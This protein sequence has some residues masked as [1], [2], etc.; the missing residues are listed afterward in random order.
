M[1]ITAQQQYMLQQDSAHICQYGTVF[2]LFRMTTLSL[3]GIE[4]MRFC[5]VVKEITSKIS[6]DDLR[7]PSVFAALVWHK[8]LQPLCSKR[9]QFETDLANLEANLPV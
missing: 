7:V 2:S 4:P 1:Q 6:E 8:Q 3:S 9:W 5:T